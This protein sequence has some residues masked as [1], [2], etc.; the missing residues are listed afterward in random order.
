LEPDRVMSCLTL[1]R[2]SDASR[3][4]D[5]LLVFVFFISIPIRNLNNR[6]LSSSNCSS[7][8]GLL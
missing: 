1:R 3:L 5:G 6:A 2:S 7:T 8:A 4:Q